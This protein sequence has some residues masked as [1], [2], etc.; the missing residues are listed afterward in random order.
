MRVVG[1]QWI[2]DDDITKSDGVDEKNAIY[3]QFLLKGLGNIG[4]SMEKL[5]SDS[6]QGYQE[7]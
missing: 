5:F 6:I 3:I 2:N 4:D 1:R 7:D